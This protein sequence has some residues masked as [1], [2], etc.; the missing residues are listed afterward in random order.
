VFDLKIFRSQTS[1]QL[2]TRL[3][4]RSIL[5][6]NTFDRTFD[7]NLLLTYRVNSGTV[8]YLGYDDHYQQADRIEMALLPGR[9]FERTNR[10]FFTK[11]SYLLRY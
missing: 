5:E 10:A 6:Y 4:A 1:Y 8:F 11:F 3:A 7:A 2:T 9:R